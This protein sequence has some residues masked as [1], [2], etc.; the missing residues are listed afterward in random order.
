MT[1]QI[2]LRFRTECLF[3][4]RDEF[5]ITGTSFRK[6]YENGKL[7]FLDKNTFKLIYQTEFD[8]Q[9]SI[10]LSVFCLKRSRIWICYA[11]FQSVIRINW[12]PRI[13]Q[14][15]VTLSNG[16]VKLYYDPV[17]SDRGALLCISKP[18]KRK[19]DP[20]VVSDQLVIARKFFGCFKFSHL[21]RV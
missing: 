7:L 18:I 20:G 19:K 21:C 16:E 17:R 11:F 2:F 4:P 8:G 5:C 1:R 15:F 12:H 3:S 9:V 10:F 6:G 13:N 14:I